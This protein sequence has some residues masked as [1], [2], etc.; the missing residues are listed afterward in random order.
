MQKELLERGKDNRNPFLSRI[1][2]GISSGVVVSGNIGSQVKMEYTVIGDTVNVASRLNS[3]AG[4]GEIIVSANIYELAKNIVSVKPLPPQDSGYRVTPRELS[5]S[6]FNRTIKPFFQRLLKFLG[7]YTPANTIAKLDGARVLENTGKYELTISRSGGGGDPYAILKKFPGRSGTIHIKEH[8]GKPG[9]PVGEG[10]VRWNEIFEAIV[11]PNL[12]Q[13]T[14]I[15]DYP[16]DISP[17]SKKERTTRALS[18]GSS[19][20]SSAVKWQMRSQNST[21]P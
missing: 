15:T 7:K 14:F 10:D 21:I 19:S 9:A 18:S 5:G 2:I 1:G 3:L 8:G 6:L 17:L 20:L 16:T 12:I 4:P 13:P 11:E